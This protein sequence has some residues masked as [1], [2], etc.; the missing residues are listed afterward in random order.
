MSKMSMLNDAK[1]II[2]ITVINH[3]DKFE[4]PKHSMV[5]FAT[6]VFSYLTYYKSNINNTIKLITYR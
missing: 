2:V 6:G 4:L 3:S 5:C 1:I